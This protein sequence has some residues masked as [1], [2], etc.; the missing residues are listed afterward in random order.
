MMALPKAAYETGHYKEALHLYREL[1][2]RDPTDNR[3]KLGIADAE[4]ASGNP[5]GAEQLY[6][7]LESIPAFHARVS[8][9]RGI[10]LMK[11]GERDAAEKAL[12]AAVTADPALWHAWNALGALYDA[13]ERW[14]DADHA[15]TEALKTK[16][17]SAM[18]YNNLGFSLLS[19]GKTQQAIQTFQTALQ[20]D[21]TL[22]PAQMNLRIALALDGKY[23]EASSGVEGRDLAAT[24]NNIGFA[25]MARGDYAKAESFFTQA[26]NSSSSYE[27]TAAK[28]LLEL[29]VLTGKGADGAG[30]S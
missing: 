29:K 1:L 24:L 4:L 30:G 12:K 21:P 17:K 8:Q 10:A 13:D 16:P 11:L 5:S 26:L 22:R 9:G 25:A 6:D 15:Y 23:S 2:V 19:Q 28:N 3:V 20:L 14:D 18:V 7:E 27:D